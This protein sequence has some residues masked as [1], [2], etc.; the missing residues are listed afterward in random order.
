MEHGKARPA[1]LRRDTAG[2][3]DRQRL[4][5]TG[6]HHHWSRL[7]VPLPDRRSRRTRLRAVFSRGA[8][9]ALFAL[10]LLVALTGRVAMQDVRGLVA[11]AEAGEPRWM[12]R[13][14]AA[15]GGSSLAPTFRFDDAGTPADLALAG[16]AQKPVALAG[17]DGFAGRGD[18][19]ERVERAGKGRRLVTVAAR[20]DDGAPAAGLVYRPA[21]YVSEMD[22]A[23][24]PRVAFVR[25]EPL[26]ADDPR[27]MMALREKEQGDLAITAA[28]RQKQLVARNVAAASASVVSA[29][30]ADSGFDVEA[31]F[32]LLLG[33]SGVEA[34]PEEAVT[35][36]ELAVDPHAW[37]GKPLPY[38]VV[39][40][41]EQK[42]LAEAV[43]FE[44]R[45]EPF[46]GQVAVAEVV[47][48]R[49][50]NPAYP[51][52][53]CG[54]VYQNKNLLNRCQFSFACDLIPDHVIPGPAW[55]QAQLIARE[56]TAG[57]L[58]VPG[59]QA[60]THY[61]ALY[62]KPNWASLFKREKQLGLHVFYS[63]YG[64]GWS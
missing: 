45:G 35:P 36:E 12:A 24:M 23:E 50:R 21:S 40:A 61:H 33:E 55:D 4:D 59:L 64:G 62:V 3:A 28:D 13:I 44:A 38:S 25:P 14:V 56:T 43:Y 46:D 48:N 10:A 47:L 26:K 22:A 17:L 20:A 42:C 32:R 63:T 30:A 8:L 53:V 31:P 6:S 57:R 9:R 58:S 49:V 5:L 52:T 51:G 54:V 16:S 7:K 18:N 15:P 19:D 41:P 60:A 34:P 11:E 37:V 2:E 27:A 39:T 1:F 29:Y